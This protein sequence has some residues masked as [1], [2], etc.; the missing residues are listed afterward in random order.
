MSAP[1]AIITGA[2]EGI[3]LEL[4]R[5]FAA[6]GHHA[7][8][9]ARRADKLE[10][11]A[12]EIA[13]A[14]HIRP[15]VI[16][17]DLGTPGAAQQ[18]QTA[19]AKA[20][21][22]PTYLVNNAG[23]GK[24]GAFTTESLGDELAMIDLNVRALTE[25]TG[26]FL[27]PIKAQRGGILNVASIASFVPGPGMAVYYASK[28]YVLSFTEALW[29]ELR[30]FGVR[31]CA[32]CPGPVVTGFQA[33]AGFDAQQMASMGPAVISAKD[34]AKAGYDGLMAGRRVVVPG[35]VNKALTTL[36]AWIPHD[37]LLPQVASRQANRERARTQKP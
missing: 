23:F 10:A 9:V 30:P 37:I 11:L 14:G 36:M 27:E 20:D 7:V 25:L 2:S 35:P 28:A 34:T 24:L 18:L 5:I 32:L 3:G 31:V 26:V 33:R 4:A 21:V 17:L 1:V 29:Q 15:L 13:A 12:S 22:T 8:L 19:L 16:A 6:K